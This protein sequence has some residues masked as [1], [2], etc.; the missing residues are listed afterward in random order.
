[1][2]KLL[3]AADA[4]LGLTRQPTHLPH[5]IQFIDAMADFPP[6]RAMHRRM[7]RELSPAELAHLQELTERTLDYGELA[8]LPANTFGHQFV[9]Y[10]RR[11]GFT[12]EAFIEAY[13]PLRETTGHQWLVKRFAR[14]H[15]VFHFLAGFETTVADEMGMLAFNVRNFQEPFSIFGLAGLPFVFLAHGRLRD[16][17]RELK[18]GWELGARA[19]NLMAAPIEDMLADDLQEVRRRLQLAA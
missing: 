8:Q 11:K 4:F 18:R 17:V 2:P 9:A 14:L 16:N 1:M 3:Q 7:F 10:M 5:I 6:F 19:R 15:D 13:P 12:Q